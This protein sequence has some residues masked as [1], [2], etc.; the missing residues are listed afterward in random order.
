MEILPESTS[1]S[2]VDLT[3]QAGNPV[4]EREEDLETLELPVVKNSSYKGLSRRSNNC[5][6]GASVSTGGALNLKVHC[7][8]LKCRVLNGYDQ[9]SF[10][11]GA[12][13]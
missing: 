7:C 12:Q 5:S 11:V 2:S 8:G 10:V 13:G 4:K 3:L 1:N 6:D 9:K